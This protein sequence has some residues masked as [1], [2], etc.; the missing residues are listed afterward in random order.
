MALARRRSFSL[1]AVSQFPVIRIVWRAV[2]EL[3]DDDGLNMAAALSYNLFTSLFPALLF[4]VALAS[5][6]RFDA[7]DRLLQ[8]AAGFMPTEV[9]DIVQTQVLK[10][11]ASPAGGLLTLGLVGAL[12]SAS[13]ATASIIDMVNRALDLRQT[14]P[15]WRQRVLAI[16]L[17]FVL[18]IFVIVSFVLVVAGPQIAEHLA[19]DVGLGRAFEITWKIGQWPVVLLL[20]SVAFGIVYR[21]AP[22]RRPHR[23][24]PGAIFS[25]VIWLGLSLGFRYYVTHFGNYN[26]TYGTIAGAIIS[27]LWLYLSALALLLGAEVNAEVQDSTSAVS[28]GRIQPSAGSRRATPGPS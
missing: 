6:F 28:A 3:I 16:F 4:F 5:F 27:L 18:A 24:M 23:V 12:W 10:I 22:E 7:L 9:F 21:L 25:M 26:K 19:T 13:S 15:W 1:L 20:V 2:S 14:R 11:T 17:T 8:S